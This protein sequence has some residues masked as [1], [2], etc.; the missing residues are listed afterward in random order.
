[1]N[2]LIV[3]LVVGVGA[4][5]VMDLWGIARKPLLGVA[6][7]DYR[8]LGRWLGHMAHGRFRHDAIAKSSAVRG[9]RVIGWTAHYLTGIAFAALLIAIGGPAWIA[10][11]DIGLALLVGVGSVA[12]PLLLMQPGMGM[13]IA[14]SR[15]PRPVAVRLQSLVTHVVFGLGLYSA[16]WVAR[17]LC[18]S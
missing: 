9:E 18:L 10:R 15:T 13:G 2:Y 17:G 5:A 4:T 7:P 3:T 16:G 6:P 1:L 14:G 12:A 11:P 8:L